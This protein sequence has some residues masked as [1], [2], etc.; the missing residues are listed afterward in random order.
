M[1]SCPNNRCFKWVANVI[2][3]VFF[4]FWLVDIS[5]LYQPICQ[6]KC[7][8][9]KKPKILDAKPIHRSNLRSSDKGLQASKYFILFV[10]FWDSPGPGF[11]TMSLPSGEAYRMQW[12]LE[13]LWLNISERSEESTEAINFPLKQYVTWE[14]I[15]YTDW[16]LWAIPNLTFKGQ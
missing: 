6:R 9:V 7:V 11:E 3:I 10:T 8:C 15:E 1:D 14:L 5:N 2:W 16:M 12:N 4:N 13:I